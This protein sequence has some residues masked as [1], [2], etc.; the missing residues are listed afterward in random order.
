MAVDRLRS[1]AE[2]LPA[3][4]LIAVGGLLLWGMLGAVTQ[5][6]R[7]WAVRGFDD[8]RRQVEEDLARELER[9]VGRPLRD[10]LRARAGVAAAYMEMR[11]ILGR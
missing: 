4:V 7:S 1:S 10:A 6:G 11:L 3:I 9:R 2:L 8:V 5:S